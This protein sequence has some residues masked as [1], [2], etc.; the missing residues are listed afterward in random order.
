[1]TNLLT[2]RSWAVCS[3]ASSK[4]HAIASETKDDDVIPIHPRKNKC[5]GVNEVHAIAWQALSKL[6]A[7]EDIR[8]TSARS[9]C[10]SFNSLQK[11]KKSLFLTPSPVI[12]VSFSSF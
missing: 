11:E 8:Y 10:A 7:T 1:M 2:D 3:T 5:K 9:G 12:K 6:S 4:V